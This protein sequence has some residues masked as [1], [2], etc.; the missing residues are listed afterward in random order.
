MGKEE[1][2]LGKE[3][4]AGGGGEARIDLRITETLKRQTEKEGVR[5]GG[6]EKG[7]DVFSVRQIKKTGRGGREKG[8]VRGAAPRG[9]LKGK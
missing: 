7:P 8:R 2:E 9:G 5:A 3:E 1:R 6:G 4:A